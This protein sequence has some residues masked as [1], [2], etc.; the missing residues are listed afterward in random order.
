MIFNKGIEEYKLAKLTKDDI[1][2]AEQVLKVKLPEAYINLMIEQNGGVPIHQC[3]PCKVPNSWAEDHVPVQGIYGIGKEGI[4]Q[5]H[6]L[7]QEWDL[8][9]N[10]VFFQ[11]MATPG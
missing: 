10:I 8:P 3:F 9:K 4:L 11:E 6:Y 5:S 1:D 7:I 2:N